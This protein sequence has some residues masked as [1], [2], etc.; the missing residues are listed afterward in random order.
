[1]PIFPGLRYFKNGISTVKQWTATD[2]KQV[3][4]VFIGVLVSAIAEPQVIQV[5]CS[6]VNFIYLTQYHSHIDHTLLVLQQA[7][8]DFHCNK[9]IFIELRCCN[10]FNFPKF[11]SLT[12]YTNTI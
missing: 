10:H 11:H 12:H 3:A 4:R 6:L 5:A 1:M 9:D 2:H 8:D 7:H